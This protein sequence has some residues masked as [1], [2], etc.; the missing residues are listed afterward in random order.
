MQSPRFITLTCTGERCDKCCANAG[1]DSCIAGS[2]SHLMRIRGAAGW[3]AVFLLAAVVPAAAQST[4]APIQGVTTTVPELTMAGT[5][6]Q[7]LA[8][9]G[10]PHVGDA[11]GLAVKLEVGTSPF[12]A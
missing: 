2:W 12:G 6:S 3:A 8:P 9:I 5:L 1:S 11:L 10:A 4:D 7:L